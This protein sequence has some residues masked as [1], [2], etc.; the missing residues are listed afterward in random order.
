M[1]THCQTPYP[2]IIDRISGGSYDL[3]GGGFCR[4]NCPEETEKSAVTPGIRIDPKNHVPAQTCQDLLGRAAIAM[5]PAMIA[6]SRL[7]I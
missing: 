3:N 5:A 1:K 2:R 4:L 6:A 7:P